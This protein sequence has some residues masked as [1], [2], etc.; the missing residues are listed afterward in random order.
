MIHK[1]STQLEADLARKDTVILRVAEATHHLASVL[2]HSG[3][4]W[5][6]PTD[7]LLAVLNAD[8]P[9]TLQ[10]LEA[11][12]AL[13]TACN[14]SLDSL[15]LPEMSTRAPVVPG[16]SDVVFEDGLFVM[17]APLVD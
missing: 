6:L 8:I 13:A 12:A 4:I 7:R 5:H 1:P 15:D 9:A 17:L 2:L 10:T 14:A 16:R 11:H 3:E